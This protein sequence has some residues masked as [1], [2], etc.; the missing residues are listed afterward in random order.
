MPPFSEQVY[1]F[2]KVVDTTSL[3]D[4]T[5]PGWGDYSDSTAISST[6]A[7]ID[8]TTI[9]CGSLYAPGVRICELES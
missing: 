7:V 9:V 6:T 2:F 5:T 8:L 4:V 1:V 3:K